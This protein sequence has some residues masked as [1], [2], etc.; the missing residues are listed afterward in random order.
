MSKG[1]KDL[2]WRKLRLYFMDVLGTKCLPI[3]KN[4]NI[5]LLTQQTFLKSLLCC[6]SM[7]KGRGSDE[8]VLNTEAVVMVGIINRE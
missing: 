1:T 7:C 6:G 2:A 8:M 5:H 4:M 3:G